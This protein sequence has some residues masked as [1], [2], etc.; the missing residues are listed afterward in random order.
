MKKKTTTTRRLDRP[1]ETKPLRI[2]SEAGGVREACGA[3]WDWLP[4]ASLLWVAR[5]FAYG[6]L[7]YGDNN[8]K[9]LD[10]D[11]EQS[12]LNHGI[13]HAFEAT[14]YPRGSIERK[15]NLAKAAWNLLAEL[16]YE[17]KEGPTSDEEYRAFVA[18]LLE[19]KSAL[20]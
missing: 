11:S 4:Y 19:G 8:W 9:G 18:E 7:K 15:W 2:T 6:G 17:E 13:A 20:G 14:E 12:P 10:F 16:W 1:I 3:R 5:V